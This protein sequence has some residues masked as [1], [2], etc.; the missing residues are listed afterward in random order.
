ME[1]LVRVSFD[2]Y[3]TNGWTRPKQQKGDCPLCYF[4]KD[5]GEHLKWWDEGKDGLWWG[6]KV[7]AMVN[8]PK[9]LGTIS[10]EDA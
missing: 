7:E 2:P 8:Q 6:C 3:L 4:P 1:F 9:Y 5:N 10:S